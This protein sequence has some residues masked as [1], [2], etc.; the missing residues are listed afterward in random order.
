[1]ATYKVKPLDPL[2]YTAKNIYDGNIDYLSFLFDIDKLNAVSELPTGEKDLKKLL[3]VQDGLS[4]IS[5]ATPVVTT[6]VDMLRL[7]I[8]AMQSQFSKIAKLKSENE[9]V[10]VDHALQLSVDSLTAENK[11][12]ESLNR[13]LKIDC[14]KWR[15][16]SEVVSKVEET[17]ADWK[18][19]N[20]AST[21]DVIN[22]EIKAQ[23]KGSLKAIVKEVVTATVD[24]PAYKKTYS[25]AV[26]LI[27][28]KLVEQTDKTFK[29][30]L[31][32][33]LK[34]NQH[35]I[36]EETVVR[37][38]ADQQEKD[39]RSRNIVINDVPE[40]SHELSGTRVA[41]DKEFAVELTKIAAADVERCF[42]AGPPLGTGS[43]SERTKPRPIVL[44]LTNPDLAKKLHKFGAGNRI[45]VNDG[46]TTSTYWV[47]PDLTRSERVANYNARKQRAKR[48]NDK[49][50]SNGNQGNS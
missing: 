43:N 34:E 35:E 33:A 21:P 8:R 50:A 28:T 27:Q 39:K 5:K 15:E 48:R 46:E 40:S 18:A 29:S 2:K 10:K 1:M 41:H 25:D 9:A 24:T 49:A 22:N 44:V 16:Y 20:P 47:N 45:T 31:T 11:T 19:S 12:L 17:L 13:Q 38:D 32:E 42:R 36:L 3:K 23:I 26:K 4:N 14:D 6:L 37:H 30:S 7:S